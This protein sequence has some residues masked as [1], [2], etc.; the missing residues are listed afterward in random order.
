M[1]ALAAALALALGTLAP[2]ARAQTPPPAPAPT[3]PAVAPPAL[4]PVVAARPLTVGAATIDVL[5][6]A[7]LASRGAAGESRVD[8]GPGAHFE[9]AVGLTRRFEVDWGFGLRLPDGGDA[10]EADR[11]ARVN[12]EAVYLTGTG[13]LANPYVRA[14]YAVLETTGALRVALGVDVLGVVPLATGTAWS[15]G[16]GLPVHVVWRDTLRLETGAQFQI[17]ISD[18]LPE[19]NVLTLPARVTAQVAPWLALGMVSGVVV[20]NVGRS[21]VDGPRVPLGIQGFFR[22]EGRIDVVAQW[23]Y[24]EFHPRTTDVV[25]FGI[26]IVARAL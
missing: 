8:T 10:V 7:G 22:V 14:R 5:A 26:G 17:A 12:R 25:G 15:V 4:L 19:T 6:G 21:N 20:G 13:D 18:A 24:P 16:A 11:Y 23:L 2:A 3:S 1:R 9:M